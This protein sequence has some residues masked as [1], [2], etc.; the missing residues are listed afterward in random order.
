MHVLIMYDSDVCNDDDELIIQV[1]D[2]GNRLANGDDRFLGQAILKPCLTPK[3]MVDHWYR[4]VS[5]A[6]EASQEFDGKVTGE[7]RLQTQYTS[8][9]PVSDLFICFLIQNGCLSIFY[10]QN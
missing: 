1:Y 2:R 7:I 4:L 3:K 6:D 5:R 10:R 8:V 9:A